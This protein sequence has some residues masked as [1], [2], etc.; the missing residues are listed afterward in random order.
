MSFGHSKRFLETKCKLWTNIHNHRLLRSWGICTC[1]SLFIASD[2]SIDRRRWSS[3]V[4]SLVSICKLVWMKKENKLFLITV[5]LFHLNAPVLF[6]TR[7]KATEIKSLKTLLSLLA[8][9]LGYLAQAS[10]LPDPSSLF[11]ILILS[12]PWHLLSENS[13]DLTSCSQLLPSDLPFVSTRLG[14]QCRLLIFQVL[15]SLL[16]FSHL[17]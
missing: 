4:W 3:L 1:I 7:W 9:L 2:F 6:S 16:M 8:Y 5:F 13:A 17:R 12:V 10:F 15:F 14:T 11:L